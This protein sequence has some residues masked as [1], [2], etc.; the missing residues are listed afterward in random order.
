MTG[1]T[2]AGAPTGNTVTGDTV[3]WRHRV[4]ADRIRALVQTD[5]L[6]VRVQPV[7]ATC[8]RVVDGAAGQDDPAMLLGFVEHRDGGYQCTLMATLDEHRSVGSLEAAHAYFEHACGEQR[9]EP[10]C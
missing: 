5:P 4:H 6:D 8:W 10:S 1:N 9:T 3:T 2:G 7:D